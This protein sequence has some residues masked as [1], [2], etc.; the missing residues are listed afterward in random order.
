MIAVNQLTKKFGK[1]LVLDN[2]TEHIR[3]GEKVA[4]IGP[5]GSDGERRSTGR[6]DAPVKNRKPG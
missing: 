3:A 2:I 1:H 4:I 6:S 5:S